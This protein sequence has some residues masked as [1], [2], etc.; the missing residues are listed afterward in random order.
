MNTKGAP[1]FW[2]A[3]VLILGG[4]WFYQS[5]TPANNI[6][7]SRDFDAARQTAAQMNRPML[8]YFTADW[9]GPCK[10]MKRS[11]W[12]DQRVE[13][14]VNNQTVPVYLDVDE[15]AVEP[16]AARYTVRSIPTVLLTDSDGNILPLPSG[17]AA[18]V[19]GVVDAAGVIELIEKAKTSSA[20]ALP[21]DLDE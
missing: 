3:M 11:V 4:V 5:Y 6:Q 20:D 21:A 7:W 16:I 1:I 18:S 19:S 12:P 9:C 10:Q 13:A 14:F 2:L 8:L 15:P 17:N